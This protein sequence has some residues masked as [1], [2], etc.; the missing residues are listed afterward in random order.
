M[1]TSEQILISLLNDGPNIAKAGSALARRQRHNVF[2]FSRADT[3]KDG[4]DYDMY[5]YIYIYLGN[6]NVLVRSRVW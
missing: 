5:L 6:V 3:S 4:C 1:Q 2:L